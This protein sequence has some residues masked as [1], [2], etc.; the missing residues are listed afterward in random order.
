MGGSYNLPLGF[1]WGEGV[2]PPLTRIGI[3]E[4]YTGSY[5]FTGRSPNCCCMLE[6]TPL[7]TVS[8]EH[9]IMKCKRYN[10]FSLS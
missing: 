8:N 7:Q 2:D 9:D 6:D 3:E 5:T 1:F 4:Q 10:F